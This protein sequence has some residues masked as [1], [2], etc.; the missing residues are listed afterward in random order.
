[1]LYAA[2]QNGHKQ[3]VDVLLK[4]GANVNL[5]CTVDNLSS[6]LGRAAEKGHTEIVEKLISAGALINK[7]SYT[8][9]VSGLGL[10]SA[11]V[12]QPTHILVQLTD[13]S[14]RPYSLPLNVTAQLELISKTTPTNQPEATPTSLTVATP[15]SRWPQSREPPSQYKVSYTPVSRGQHKLHVQVNDREINGSPFTVTVY[16]DP[17]QLGHPVRT[18]TG[19]DHPYYIAFNSHQEMI[20]SEYWVIECLS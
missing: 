9:Q 3:T 2:C 17:R 12:N 20:V 18:V 13:S 14:G 1:P 8:C 10:T 5:T 16:S 19:L 7:H 6:T 4:N 15:A 11:T